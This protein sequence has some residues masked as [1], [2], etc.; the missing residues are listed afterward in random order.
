MWIL[1]EV[2][3]TD[4]GLLKKKIVYS[5]QFVRMIELIGNLEVSFGKWPDLLQA[6]K[7]EI[8]SGVYESLR[9]HC[10]LLL[11]PVL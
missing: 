2:T 5:K 6:N 11:Q 1:H 4:L 3:E 8:V 9:E 7:Q 10:P